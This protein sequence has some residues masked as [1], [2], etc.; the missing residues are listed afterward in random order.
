MS[1]TGSTYALWDD[2]LRRLDGG[3]ND[4]SAIITTVEEILAVLYCRSAGALGI[5][6]ERH[7]KALKGL[8]EWLKERTPEQARAEAALIARS[9]PPIAL[10]DERR[11]IRLV[12]ERLELLCPPNHN[13]TLFTIAVI[14]DEL[15]PV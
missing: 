9:T 1:A 8:L 14:L 15:A 7:A 12:F 3:F 13:H 6:V 4:V 11:V 5:E 2:L 10:S